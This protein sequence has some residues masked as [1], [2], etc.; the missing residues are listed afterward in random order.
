[1]RR[2]IGI[3][4][5]IVAGTWIPSSPAMTITGQVVDNKARPVQGAEVVVCE[6]YRIGVFDQDAKMISPVVKTDAEGR[7]ALQADVTTQRDVFIVARKPGLAYAWEWL[8]CSLDTLG[9]KHFPLVLEPAGVLAG[10][11]VDPNGKPVAGA[12]IQATPVRTYGFSAVIEGWHVPGPQ[13]WFEVST[14]AQGRFRFEQLAADASAGLRVQA[15]GC[16]TRHAFRLHI[17]ESCGFPVGGPDIR[18]ALPRTGTVRGRVVDREGR[19]AVGVELMIHSGRQHEDITNLYLV[20]RATSDRAGTFTFEGIPEGPQ[21]IKVLTPEQGPVL[22]TS[23][24]SGVSVQAG[25]TTEATIRLDKG[26]VL[27]VTVL[28]AR[29]RRPMP[30]ARLDASGQ[31][32]RQGQVAT[33]DAKGVARVRVPADSY[34]VVVSAPHFSRSQNTVNVPEGQTVRREALLPASPTMSGRVFDPKGQPMADVTVVIHPFG[35]RMY[36]QAQG[37]FEGGYDERY[38]PKWVMAQVAGSGWAAAV[39]VS[40]PA[41]PVELRPGPAWTLTGRVADPNGVAIPAARVFLTLDSQFCLSDMGVEVLSDPAG[42]FEMKAIP[43]VQ[44]DFKYSLSVAVAG[45]GPAH[46]LKLFP[47]GPAG[48]SVDLGTIRLRPADTSVSG[49]VVDARGLPAAR[50]PVFLSEHKLMHQPRKKTATNEKG[51]FTLTGACRGPASL[52]AS[53][54]SSPGGAGF[55]RTCLPARN[56]KIVIGKDLT[57]PPEPWT[58]DGA[59]PQ[60]TDLCPGLWRLQTD[61]RPLLLCLV[62][63]LQQS[64]RQCM[65]DLARKV[66]TL[67]AKGVITIGVLTAKVDSKQH[68]AFRR[69]NHITFPNYLAGDDFEARKAAW[70]IQSVPW[71]I[72]TDKKHTVV[73]GGFRLDELDKRVAEALA[74]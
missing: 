56:V 57:D 39:P 28:D 71:L 7:F 55:L 64:S 26:N 41:R 24:T 54:P 73:A 36:T 70:G 67:A 31:Q 66:D 38:P 49:I 62:D 59:P 29:S 17:M 19:P 3:C 74:R 20:R 12:R 50:I 35:D 21:E 5:W 6:S 1:M 52:Q 68:E 45:Y 30:G 37:R 14:D 33:A 46:Y 27:E 47:S 18:L 13:V 32:R 61:G 43:P 22:W 42:R 4:V 58:R 63:P 23:T 72:L 65:I 2:T 34:T 11:V 8:N 69:A 60:P 51:E 16:E 44:T 48:A 10:Q 15:P 9:R 40:D 25:G 53:F